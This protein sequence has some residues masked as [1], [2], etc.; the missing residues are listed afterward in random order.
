MNFEHGQ[1]SMD[2]E[3]RTGFI[4]MMALSGSTPGKPPGPG[5]LVAL[6]QQVAAFAAEA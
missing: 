2:A 5:S 1:A 6:R 4:Q 3:L